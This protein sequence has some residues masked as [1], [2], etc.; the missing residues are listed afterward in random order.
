MKSG[1]VIVRSGK[2]LFG[3]YSCVLKKCNICSFI[4][5][6]CWLIM[7]SFYV[8]ETILFFRT[9]RT[10][11]YWK[12]K[13]YYCCSFSFANS[14]HMILT[15]RCEAWSFRWALSE[16]FLKRQ[17]SA[18]IKTVEIYIPWYEYEY[19]HCMCD[20]VWLKRDLLVYIS[21]AIIQYPVE[22]Q[23]CRKILQTISLCILPT[24]S[25]RK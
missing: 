1:F 16:K 21:V 5:S 25:D 2:S 8:R 24:T 17:I 18:L 15:S 7:A 22:F 9:S 12:W 14:D 11:P 13:L 6:W 3:D 20:T 4:T 10:E 23:I 19:R